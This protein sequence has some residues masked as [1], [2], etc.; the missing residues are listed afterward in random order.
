[1][2]LDQVIELVGGIAQT[3]ATL[4]VAIFLYRQTNRLKRIELT[5]QAIDAYNF[6][7]SVA[8]ARD[9]NLRALDSLGRQSVNRIR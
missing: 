6:V 5:K 2:T 3:L 7:N 1:M 4:I 9:E 8:L